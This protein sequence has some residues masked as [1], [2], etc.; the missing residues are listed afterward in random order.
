M[1]TFHYNYEI[2]FGSAR[3]LSK[4]FCSIGM[5]CGKFCRGLYLSI[6]STSEAVY[7]ETPYIQTVVSFW[8]SIGRRFFFI[9]LV[10]WSFTPKNDEMVLEHIKNWLKFWSHT[11][12]FIKHCGQFLLSRFILPFVSCPLSPWNILRKTSYASL[13]WKQRHII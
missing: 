3:L 10:K 9:G 11:Q 7:K 5:K 2:E 8:K 4:S 6:I 13:P 12:I 1:L